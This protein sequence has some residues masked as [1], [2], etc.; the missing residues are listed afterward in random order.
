MPDG[1]PQSPPQ[2]PQ[3]KEEKSQ[4]EYTPGQIVYDNNGQVIGLAIDTK[5]VL[6]PGQYVFIGVTFEKSDYMVT[7]D[8]SS[9]TP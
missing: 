9:S 7:S 3:Y 1:T 6:K 2:Q 8:K 4:E 5:T